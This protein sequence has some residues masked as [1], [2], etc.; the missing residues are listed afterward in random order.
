MKQWRDRLADWWARRTIRFRLAVRYAV[1]GTLLI[2]GFSATLYFYVNQRMARPLAFQLRRDLEVVHQQLTV[3]ADGRM[4]WGGREVAAEV[5]WPAGNP[6][7]EI[8]D[9]HGQLVRRLWPFSANRVSQVPN[10]PARGRETV[11]I[12]YVAPDL[13][14][15][16]CLLY[17]SP[18]PRD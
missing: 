4:S 1:G 5:P 10:A 6:W 7:F 15:R 2:A 3:T 14:L 12:F 9:E 17:T 13:Q 18:S 8:W 16:V 11:S